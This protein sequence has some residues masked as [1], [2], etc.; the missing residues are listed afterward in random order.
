MGNCDTHQEI[1]YLNEEA[2]RNKKEEILLEIRNEFRK[3]EETIYRLRNEDVHYR[4]TKLI[5]MMNVIKELNP[6]IHVLENNKEKH[7]YQPLQEK[8]RELFTV[9]WKGEKDLFYHILFD[10]NEFFVKNNISLDSKNNMGYLGVNSNEV[11]TMN[12]HENDK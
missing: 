10:I 12:T 2:P 6:I 9:F 7:D 3:I 4:M 8:I 5:F 1:I 11:T